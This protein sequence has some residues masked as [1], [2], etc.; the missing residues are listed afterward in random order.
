MSTQSQPAIRLRNVSKRFAFTPDMPQ[1]VLETAI[2]FFTRRRRDGSHDLWAV[3]DVSF[4][5][6]PGQSLG[7]IGRNGSGKSTLLKIIARLSLIHISEPTRP[8]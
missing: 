4:D 7:I 8:Y 6:F 5:I 2:A 3:R 1:S